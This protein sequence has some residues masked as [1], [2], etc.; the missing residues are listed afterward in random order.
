MFQVTQQI[1]VIGFLIILSCIDVFTY[2]KK[3]GYIPAILT[4]SF[5]FFSFLMSDK[6]IVTPMLVFSILLAMMLT[7]IGAWKGFADFKTYVATG[8]SLTNLNH[9]FIFT[10]ILY[11]LPL[12]VGILLVA[13]KYNIF[14]INFGN[15]K[16]IANE[17]QRNIPFIPFIL[18]AY[19]IKG[20]LF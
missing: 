5:L 2:D 12:L 19:L 20:W 15:A 4:S 14:N 7:D 16:K 1:L 6:F 18:I 13:S 11:A 3:K 8:I 9:L 17:T 10:G